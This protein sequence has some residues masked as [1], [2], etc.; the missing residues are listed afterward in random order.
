MHASGSR[1]DE[2][3]LVA[4]FGEARLVKTLDSKYEL[5]GGSHEDRLAARE[6]VSMFFHE[7]VEEFHVFVFGVSS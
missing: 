1:R 7:A 4:G 3:E 2:G 6:W 5:R